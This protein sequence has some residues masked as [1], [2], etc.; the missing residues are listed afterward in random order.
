MASFAEILFSTIKDMLARNKN[1]TADPFLKLNTFWSALHGLISINMLG[2]NDSRDELNA[3]VLK[4][5]LV[6]FISG[7]RG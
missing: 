6:G 2:K 5:F 7:M 1:T 3:M 4:D